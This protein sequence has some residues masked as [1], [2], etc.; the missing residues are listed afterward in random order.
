[1]VAAIPYTGARWAAV[2][3][4]ALLIALAVFTVSR[5][6]QVGFGRACLLTISGKDGRVSTSITVAALWTAIVAWILV[7]LLFR[8]PPN[9]DDALAELSPNY[10]LL[11]GGPYAALVLAKATVTARVTS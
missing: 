5:R 7:S 10:L 2:A 1:M 11:L 3:V 4:T 6:K 8:W 9:W